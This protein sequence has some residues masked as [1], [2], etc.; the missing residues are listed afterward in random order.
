MC[1]WGALLFLAL[2][3]EVDFRHVSFGVTC[4]DVS[5]P[6]KRLLRD[7]VCYLGGC[8]GVCGKRNLIQT[9]ER[10]SSRLG[11][12]VQTNARESNYRVR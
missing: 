12:F 8:L 1:Y 4:H 5:L 3:F 11:F 10:Y 2:G 6:E 9:A 7:L